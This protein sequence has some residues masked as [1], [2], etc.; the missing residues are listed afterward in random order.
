M[1]VETLETFP[2]AIVAGD[3]V[4]VS[5]SDGNHPS[6]EWSLAVLLR[7]EA[8]VSSSFDAIPDDEGAFDI[9]IPATDSANLSPGSYLVTYRW[10]E[11][12]TGEKISEPKG[13]LIVAADPAQ[14]ATLTQ[15]AQTLAA[16][17]AALL[18]LSSGSNAIVNFNGQSFTRKNIKE[19]QD[20]I[21]R[22]QL[23]VDQEQKNID[24]AFG[25][26]RP[27]GIGIRFSC[28]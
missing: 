17:E 1:A 18:N 19:L 10:T 23:I 27:T 13:T 11:T 8:G 26:K 24:I 14:N 22:Q 6:E 25:I 7:S 21:D 28:T 3:T 2:R 12:I 9:L 20:A 15:A 5:I 4:R 16:M